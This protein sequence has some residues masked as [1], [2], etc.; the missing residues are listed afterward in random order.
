MVNHRVIT[1]R[2]RTNHFEKIKNDAASK[3]YETLSEY[4]RSSLL[5][6]DISLHQKISEIYQTVVKP[7]KPVK[8]NSSSINL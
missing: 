1:I 6:D 5:K 7:K 4:V 3:G 8:E 2:L